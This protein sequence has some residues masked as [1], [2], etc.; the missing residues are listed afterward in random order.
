[1]AVGEQD[2]KDAAQVPGEKQRVFV[3]EDEIS[4]D[5]GV[6]I[7][8]HGWLWHCNHTEKKRMYKCPETSELCSDGIGGIFALIE[9][10]LWHFTRNHPSKRCRCSMDAKLCSDAVGGCWFISDGTLW[11]LLR[12]NLRRLYD[13]PNDVEMAPDG[14]GGVWVLDD[15]IL[16]HCTEVYELRKH[17]FPHA[18][19]RMQSDCV[20]GVW[21][22]ASHDPA[23]SGQ[24]SGG[25]DGV[26]YHCNR[27]RK[28]EMFD[29]PADTEICSDGVGGLWCIFDGWLHLCREGKMTKKYPAFPK[30]ADIESDGVGGV[31]ALFD[32]WLWHCS[33]IDNY[34]PAKLKARMDMSIKELREQNHLTRKYEFTHGHRII[35]GM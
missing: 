25:K 23:S 27:A 14:V 22:L 13:Y 24:S 6:W 31:W 21:V 9:G 15:G 11:H 20:E 12:T 10:W 34:T 7:V 28:T 32:G 30:H 35:G 29:L 33:D 1:M 17:S 8:E 16:Y 3:T 26:L 5:P 18:K 4:K 19:C 2:G